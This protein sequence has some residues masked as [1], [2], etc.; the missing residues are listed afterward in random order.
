MRWNHDRP[1]STSFG[2]GAC[3]VVEAN[4]LGPSGGVL[5]LLLR[6]AHQDVLPLR[7]AFALGEMTIRRRRLDFAPPHFLDR[8]QVDLV[9]RHLS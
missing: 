9:D 5:V 6:Q 4:P 2:S 7:V 3:P 8:R 1:R